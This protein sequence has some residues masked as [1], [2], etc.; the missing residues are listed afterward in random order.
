MLSGY[1]SSAAI[2]DRVEVVAGFSMD[3]SMEEAVSKYPCASYSDSFFS[4]LPTYH[5]IIIGMIKRAAAKTKMNPWK[6]GRVNG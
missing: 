5:I 4:L 6:M 1:G 3:G 2:T